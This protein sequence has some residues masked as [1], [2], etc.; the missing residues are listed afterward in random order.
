MGKATLTKRYPCL[1]SLLTKATQKDDIDHLNKPTL[2]G[3]LIQFS[4]IPLGPWKLRLIDP[5]PN[6]LHWIPKHSLVIGITVARARGMWR[7]VTL[8]LSSSVH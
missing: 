4:A 1:S 6:L 5:R 7:P 3:S 2:L 8:T